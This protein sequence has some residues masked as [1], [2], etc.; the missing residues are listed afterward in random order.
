MFFGMMG[1]LVGGVPLLLIAGLLGLIL[2]RLNTIEKTQVIALAMELNPEATL[3]ATGLD[4]VVENIA[5]RAVEE[6][7]SLTAISA[8]FEKLFAQMI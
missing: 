2:G 8:A 1:L 7:K 3:E 6:N 5:R 4:H